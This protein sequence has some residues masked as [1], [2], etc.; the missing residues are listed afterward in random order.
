MRIYAGKR[1][2]CVRTRSSVAARCHFFHDLFSCPYV[3]S[4]LSSFSAVIVYIY[5]GCILQSSMVHS[6]LLHILY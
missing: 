6:T 4:V 3:T 5:P 1:R 2:W